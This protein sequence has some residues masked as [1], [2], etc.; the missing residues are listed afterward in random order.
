M[1][2]LKLQLAVR[3]LHVGGAERQFLEL[4]K[5]I[6]KNRFDV[7]VVVLRTGVLDVELGAKGIKV[8]NLGEAGLRDPRTFL[9][10]RTLIADERPDLIYSFMFDVNVCA[11]IVRQISPFRPKLVWGIFGSEPDFAKG[12]RFLRSLF[13]L[14]RLLERRADLITSDSYRGLEFLDRYGFRL[15]NSAV[16]F[17]GTDPERFRRDEQARA[18]FRSQHRLKDNVTAIGICSRLVHMKGYPILAAAA[19]RLLA[20]RSDV[21]FFAAGGGDERIVTECDRVLGAERPRFTWIGRVLQP[22][23][24]LSGW[25]L[26]CS[27]SLYGEGFSNAI[28]EA[29]A[30]ELPCVVTDVGDARRQVGDTG[31][32][33]QPGSEEALYQGLNAMLTA[34]D[35]GARGSAAR[36]RVLE[37]FTLTKMVRRTEAA[38]AHVVEDVLPQR[39]D[40][41]PALL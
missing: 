37:H 9:R 2:K 36:Q 23:A 24:C 7:T 22:E 15:S 18:D 40:Q 34:P 38:L 10:W 28:I 17:S 1:R 21:H 29:M 3:S 19:R 39:W 12:P 41:R 33:V 26:Y 5:A 32:I 20:E 4:A 30:C 13:S 14:L 25:D 8:V 27:S 11:A 35:R 6:D 16:I 31:V